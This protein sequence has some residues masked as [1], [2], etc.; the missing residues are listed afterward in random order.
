MAGTEDH[1]QQCIMEVEQGW[2][3]LQHGIN[4]LINIIEGN[5]DDKKS[6]SFFI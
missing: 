1:H 3:V 6:P 4:K 2:A 5:D